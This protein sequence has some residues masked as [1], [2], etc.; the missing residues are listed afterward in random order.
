VW[1]SVEEKGYEFE[2]IR[3]LHGWFGE[4]KEMGKSYNYIG[5]YGCLTCRRLCICAS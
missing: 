3:G 1:K 4:R 2:R 5:F